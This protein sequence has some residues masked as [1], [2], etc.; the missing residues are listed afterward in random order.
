L[1]RVFLS[2]KVT[3][4]KG[5]E[6]SII[7]IWLIGEPLRGR[8]YDRIRQPHCGQQLMSRPVKRSMMA[9]RFYGHKK[10]RV[11]IIGKYVGLIRKDNGL[12]T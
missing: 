10:K 8:G 11:R 2:N 1:V 12:I 4:H 7:S 6:V 3:F 5:Y 9:M